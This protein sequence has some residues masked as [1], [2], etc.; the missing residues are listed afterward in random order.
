MTPESF[1]MNKQRA[2][3]YMN[4]RPRVFIIDQYAGWDPRYQIKT[5]VISTRPYHALFMKQ[6]LIRAEDGRQLPLGTL[7]VGDYLGAT[8]LTRQRMIVGM[9]AL[10]DV[11]IIAVGRE[12]M[13][14][15]VRVDHRFARQIGDV[16]DLRRKAAKEALAAASE[17]TAIG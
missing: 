4:L 6:M 15:V 10:T 9:V 16:I 8:A 7:G 3:D 17:Q 12:A 11:T 5:R 1:Q 2:V 13:E 14:Q